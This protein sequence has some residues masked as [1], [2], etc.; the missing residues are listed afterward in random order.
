MSHRP[1]VR[2]RAQ[3][4]VRVRHVLEERWNLTLAQHPSVI[5]YGRTVSGIAKK[6]GSASVTTADS[7]DTSARIVRIRP[8]QRSLTKEVSGRS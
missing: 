2:V 8:H 3:V 4:R 5:Y 6:L 1:V 7:T